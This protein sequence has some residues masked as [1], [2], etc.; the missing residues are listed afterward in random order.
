MSKDFV[1]AT[2]ILTL[3]ALPVVAQSSSG[4]SAETLSGL[5]SEVRAL[6]MAVARSSPRRSASSTGVPSLLS[7][8]QWNAVTGGARAVDRRDIT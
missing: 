4:G 2:M 3:C 6:R 7:S 5:L 8:F 1:V